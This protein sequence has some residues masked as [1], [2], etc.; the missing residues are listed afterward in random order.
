M[1]SAFTSISSGVVD[2]VMEL[3]I[4]AALPSRLILLLPTLVPT[5][6][7][8]KVCFMLL[9]GLDILVKES[10]LASGVRS[11]TTPC[12]FGCEVINRMVFIESSAVRFPDPGG[13]SVGSEAQA[14]FFKPY[15]LLSSLARPPRV[16]P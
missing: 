2:E 6:V 7:L 15:R 14:G 13:I 5:L 16:C 11:V 12:D 10:S 1:I 8:E 9:L 3:E 4:S